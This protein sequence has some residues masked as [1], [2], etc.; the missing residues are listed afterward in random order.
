MHYSVRCVALCELCVAVWGVVCCCVSC[1]YGVVFCCV[2]TYALQLFRI[3]CFV[4]LNV[5]SSQISLKLRRISVRKCSVSAGFY[6]RPLTAAFFCPHIQPEQFWTSWSCKH[7]QSSD[8]LSYERLCYSASIYHP[9]FGKK[10]S[11]IKNEVRKRRCQGRREHGF[12]LLF[13][14]Q[15]PG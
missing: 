6:F 7:P 12:Y 10:N 4:N 13:V 3:C 2:A 14:F 5:F 11:R 15:V 9:S 1:V 8:Q